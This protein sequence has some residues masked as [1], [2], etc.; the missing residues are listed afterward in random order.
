ME[1]QRKNHSG[2]AVGTVFF[3]VYGHW[4]KSTCRRSSPCLTEMSNLDQ[5]LGISYF[6][7]LGETQQRRT[8]AVPSRVSGHVRHCRAPVPG[9]AT[10]VIDI[11]TK[12]SRE[13]PHAILAP[14]FS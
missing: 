3:R 13:D 5:T 2:G 7:S 8:I 10:Y 4:G 12:E 1:G 6:G 14:E 11:R 9:S